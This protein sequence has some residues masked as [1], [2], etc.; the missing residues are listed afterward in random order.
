M[1]ICYSKKKMAELK[2]REAFLNEIEKKLQ[3]KENNL[4]VLNET[5]MEQEGKLFI[6]KDELSLKSIEMNKE[7]EKQREIL[8]TK[9]NELKFLAKNKNKK[10]VRNMMYT[11][12]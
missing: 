10:F 2:A 7:F 4:S 8:D 11:D 1:G 3:I 5:L 9:I 6:F 12:C